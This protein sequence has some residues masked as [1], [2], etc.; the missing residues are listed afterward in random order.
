MISDRYLHFIPYHINFIINCP[1]SFSVEKWNGENNLSAICTLH[2]GLYKPA[3]ACD[4]A[5]TH[6]LTGYRVS[7]RKLNGRYGLW[8][9]ML[10]DTNYVY[11]FCVT[12]VQLCRFSMKT[13][14][15][16]NIC[17]IIPTITPISKA[18]IISPIPGSSHLQC[19]VLTAQMKTVNTRS[20]LR[21]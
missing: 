1:S 15:E 2:S 14:E 13:Y 3:H 8:Q 7:L 18:F 17:P 11:E 6:T 12:N 4:I 21:A 20:K 16:T 19:N 5:D 10:S 9:T